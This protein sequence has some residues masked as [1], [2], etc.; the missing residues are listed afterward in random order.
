MG[1]PLALPQ[2]T[3]LG[4]KIR[5]E[6]DSEFGL[7]LSERPPL[8]TDGDGVQG[9]EIPSL[10]ATKQ[11]GEWAPPGLPPE[12]TGKGRQAAGVGGG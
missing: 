7:E 9:W 4:R 5:I 2:R 6:G 1:V 8:G 11:G 10:A 3:R 12:K